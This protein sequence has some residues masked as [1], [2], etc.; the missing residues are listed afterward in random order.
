MKFAAAIFTV[1]LIAI[2][3]SAQTQPP[4]APTLT[5]VSDAPNLPADLYYGNVKIKPLRLRPGTNQAITI[6]DADFFVQQQYID[7][8]G[9][10][11]DSSGFTT[12][13]NTVNQ[14]P[15]GGYGERDNPSCD[16]V[17]IS[18]GFYQ[19]TEFQ[20]RGY[21][22]YRFYQVGLGRRPTYREFTPD[23]QRIGGS[24]SPDQEVASKAIYTNDF[25]Q[26]AEFKALYDGLSNQAFV[27]KLVQTAG[28]TLANKAQLV[29]ALDGGQQTRAQVL[30]SVA[31][32][33][34][35]FNK[36]YNQAFVAMQY[37]GYL[38]RDPDQ[39]GFATWVQTLE[40][41][42]DYRHMIFGFLYSAEYRNRF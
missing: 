26:R 41:S 42:G 18:A 30:R 21:F 20:G 29:S 9:R 24:Q 27:D 7:F 31:E 14:C 39:T 38:K 25:A 11:P 10:M 28:V 32:S 23:L 1:A 2:S 33:Q 3:V 15:N 34:E 19:S 17:H 36:Y 16:R 5:I 6:D 37:F 8:L 12:W 35:V 13:L 40:T 22:V 4:A